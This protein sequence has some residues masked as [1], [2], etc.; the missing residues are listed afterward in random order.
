ME[1]KPLLWV[2]IRS[3][4]EFP[5]LHLQRKPWL[6]VDSQN[7]SAVGGTLPFISVGYSKGN[8]MQHSRDNKKD[9]VDA[10]VSSCRYQ[11]SS[12]E[13]DAVKSSA[14]QEFTR[15]AYIYIYIYIH[16]SWGSEQPTEPDTSG[17]KTSSLNLCSHPTSAVKSHHPTRRQSSRREQTCSRKV[18]LKNT[19]VTF[20]RRHL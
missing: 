2:K 16:S 3:G 6:I 10:Q 9:R 1:K 7:S 18:L 12:L 20:D 17:Y 4:W 14:Q 5:R 15:P 11:E 19:C 8:G 13:S